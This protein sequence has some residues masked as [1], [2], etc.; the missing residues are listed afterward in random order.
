MKEGIY[1]AFDVG[2]TSIKAGAI[3]S[4]G[5]IM[6]HTVSEYPSKANE[7]AANI[8]D[9]FVQMAVDLLGL[10]D[11]DGQKRIARIGYAFPGPFDYEQ[12]ISYIRG[13]NKFDALYG[14]QVGEHLQK[15][16]LLD[17]R[18]KGRIMPHFSLR[19]ENDASLF[20]IGEAHFGQAA[21]F[22]KA[23]CLT[24]GTGIGSGFV[25]SGKLITQ[26]A[27]VP[28]SGWVYAIP[29]RSS[30]ADDYISRRGLLA[31]ASEQGINLAGRD[32]KELAVSA[33]SGEASTQQLFDAFGERMAE[34]LATVLKTFNPGIIVLG[35]QISKSGELFIPSFR[36]QLINKEIHA[37]VVVSHDTLRSTLMGI[38]HILQEH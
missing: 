34:A 25:E 27:D 19:F 33:R 3:D 9:H 4:S 17:T 1:L 18:L 28:V 24:L 6:E 32:V 21:T 7:S 23:V 30:I 22:R 15:M 2:G 38:Y 31:L 37:S 10:A 11:P 13:L 26:Q 16:M 29:Y 12:G 36:R 14:M 20:A 8:F 35:G 5:R